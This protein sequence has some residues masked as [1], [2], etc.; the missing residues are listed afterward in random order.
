MAKV[1]PISYRKTKHKDQ[2]NNRRKELK[3]KRRLKTLLTVTRTMLVI[4][5]SGGAFWLLTLPHW[6][7]N[8][9][10]QIEVEGNDYLTDNEIR[11]LVP[12][13]YP[14]PLLTLSTEKLKE[15]LKVKAP[16][17]DIVVKR[18]ML[19]PKVTIKVDERKPVAIAFAPVFS[20]KIKKTKITQIGYLDEQGILVPTK[21]YQSLKKEE[22]K[23]LPE[24]KIIGVTEQYLSYWEELYQLVNQSEVKIN[25]I[26]WQNP[27][28]LILKTELGEV[29]IGA[30]TSR[31]PKQLMLLA[32]MKQLPQKVPPSQIIY[33]DL[34]DPDFPS[35][36]QKEQPEMEKKDNKVNS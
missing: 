4:A 23:I 24:F 20:P 10:H 6:V 35:I 29:H 31:F 12:L 14:Q 3:A 26:N 15:E 5:F 7:I 33:I 18:E 28:N 34:S 8:S 19:P 32:K 27:N 36:K 21:Y 1:V 13:S 11:M 2:I 16:F 9:S 30:Y 25:E 22:E 17:S